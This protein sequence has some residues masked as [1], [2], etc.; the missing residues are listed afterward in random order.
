MAQEYAYLKG[1]I[2]GATGVND[3]WISVTVDASGRLPVVIVGSNT[4]AN[5]FVT[6]T[7]CLPVQAFL[8]AYDGATF[9]LVRVRPWETAVGIVTQSGAAIEAVSQLSGP[10]GV[11]SI[12]IA[13]VQ[14]TGALTIA[15]A[16]GDIDASSNTT[17]YNYGSAAIMN[18]AA[19]VLAGPS[20]ALPSYAGT[21]NRKVALLTDTQ[22]SLYTQ[23]GPPQPNA[24]D[25]PTANFAIDSA[26]VPI[27]TSAG[28]LWDFYV[29]S[30]EAG[31]TIRYLQVFN[32]A[33]PLAYNDV[34]I[35]SFVINGPGPICASSLHHFLG[36]HGLYFSAGIRLGWSTT[37]GTYTAAGAPLNN[38]NYTFY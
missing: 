29:V 9:D 28:T 10:N 38:I 33:T 30:R 19:Y 35:F 3:P 22:G 5:N 1:Q 27:K 36:A 11:G 13:R 7:N 37:P 23:P 34:P 2:T 31:G 6:P 17:E 25:N 26:D 32:K 21:A 18:V 24:R 12:T 15:S 16:V 14:A 8:Q 4:P 20:T